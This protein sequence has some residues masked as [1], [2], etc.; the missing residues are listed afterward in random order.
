MTEATL[1]FEKFGSY[2]HAS[3]F[4][5]FSEGTLICVYPL[6]KSEMV[7]CNAEVRIPY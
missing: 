4:K 6:N 7:Y 1:S 3:Y 2:L 5:S